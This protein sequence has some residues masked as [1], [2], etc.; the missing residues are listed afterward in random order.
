MQLELR[1]LRTLCAIADTGSVSKAATAL[2]VAQPALTAQLQPIEAALGGS[3]FDRD[4]RG[5]RPTVLGQLVLSRAKVLLPAVADLQ[6]DVT[7]L[8]GARAGVLQFR[9][10]SVGVPF[11]AGLVRRLEAAFEDSLVTTRVSWSALDLMHAVAAS[12][13]DFAVIGVCGDA[14]PPAGNG[15]AWAP[16]ATDPIFVLLSDRH[17][18][19]AG[20]EVALGDLADRRW[21]VSPGDGCFADCF[22]AACSRAG[23]TPHTMYEVDTV[24]CIDLAQNGDAVVLCQPTFRQMTGLVALP[25]AGAPLS[26]RHL[27]GWRADGPAARFAPA[28]IELSRQ[29]YADALDR[30][31]LYR[32][33]LSDHPGFGVDTS[34]AS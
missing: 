4:R 5:A 15:M 16:I 32:P 18:A 13:S 2:G 11:L 30:N 23:F 31:P 29:A 12:R 14:E 22:A 24:S 3:L 33:W 34:V 7:R 19:T 6:Q 8:A 25:I 27:I 9:I 10:G 17:P 28:V 1:H 21:A 26:W 20:S